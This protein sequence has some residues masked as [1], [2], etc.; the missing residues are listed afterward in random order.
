M[1]TFFTN[2]RR[3]SLIRDEPQA[4]SIAA[5]LAMTVAIS[6]SALAQNY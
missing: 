3:L 6:A 1:G 5:A 2:R 4:Q